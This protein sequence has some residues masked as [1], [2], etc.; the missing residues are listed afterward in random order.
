M[1]GYQVETG[2][3]SIFLATCFLVQSISETLGLMAAM[4]TPDSTLAFLAISCLLWVSD[5]SLSRYNIAF[6]LHCSLSRKVW[7]FTIQILLLNM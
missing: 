3:F 1:I 5:Q 7:M 4:V 6:A 2:K